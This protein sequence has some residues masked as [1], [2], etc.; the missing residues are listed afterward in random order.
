MSV[1]NVMSWARIQG[2]ASP[3]MVAI[4]TIFGTKVNVC[5]LM[6]VIVCRSDTPSP[7]AI[8]VPRMGAATKAAVRKVSR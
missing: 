1:R 7:I 8:A 2:R 3:I 4:P 6:L 5:S